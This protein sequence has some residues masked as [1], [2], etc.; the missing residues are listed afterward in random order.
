LG[1]LFVPSV[2]R[3]GFFEVHITNSLELGNLSRELLTLL[4]QPLEVPR[5]LAAYVV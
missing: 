2:K 4:L 5:V 3:G 1:E